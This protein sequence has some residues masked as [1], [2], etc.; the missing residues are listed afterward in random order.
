MVDLFHESFGA[1]PKLDFGKKEK[2]IV[3]SIR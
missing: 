3:P 2:N 1:Q